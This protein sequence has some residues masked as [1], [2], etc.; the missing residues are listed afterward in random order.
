MSSPNHKQTNTSLTTT[1]EAL[2]QLIEIVAK[3]RSPDGGCPWDKA[4]TPQT[5]IPYIIEEAYE[6][7][8][9]IKSGDCQALAEELGDLLLQVVLQAQIASE[10]NQFTLAEVAQGISEKL[11]RRHPH[12]F[13]EIKV[14]S[15]EEIRQNWEEIKAAE[16][17]AISGENQPLSSKLSRYAR[18]LPPLT[19][20]M[21]ISQKAAAVGFEWDDV[22]GVWAKFFEEIDEFKQAIA[23]ESKA[24][25]QAELGDIL[26][27][28]INLA[29]WYGLDPS[30]AL[31][32]TNL[33]F[34]QRFSKVEAFAERP[35]TE[36]TIEE[37]ETLWAQAKAQ[38]AQQE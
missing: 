6:V 34:I 16:K 35:L 13:G 30:E 7:V 36:Y 4:Q 8:D 31:H 3:L 33:K 10:Y 24:Q 25:Q 37:L 26:F 15:I 22:E 11:I 20:G 38:L 29:R 18:T 12:V 19:A 9:A 17:G 2:K 32:E 28:L 1:L 21:K 27:V 23:H 5:L 14:N